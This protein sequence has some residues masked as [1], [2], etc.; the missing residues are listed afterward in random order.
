MSNKS[1][2]KG[3]FNISGQRVVLYTHSLTESK[4]FI[5]FITKLAK[6]NNLNKHYFMSMFDGSKDNYLIERIRS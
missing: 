4:A 1:L 3:T 2:F 6:I 5:N